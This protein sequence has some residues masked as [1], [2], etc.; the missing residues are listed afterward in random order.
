MVTVH[1]QGCIDILQFLF[2]F[3]PSDV[4]GGSGSGKVA[5]PLKV[6]ARQYR[7]VAEV[8]CQELVNLFV[9]AGG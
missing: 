6:G 5:Q 7:V 9:R 2:L 8:I 1:W 4:P 3:Q